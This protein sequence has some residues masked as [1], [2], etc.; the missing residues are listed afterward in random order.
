MPGGRPTKLTQ[1]QRAYVWNALFEYIQNED[2][3]TIVGFV[4]YDPAAN[5]YDVTRDNINDWPEFST[6]IKKATTKQE[7]YL[8]KNASKNRINPTFAIFRLKQPVHGYSDKTQTDLT[9]NGKDLPTPILGGVSVRSDDSN[10]Q[11]S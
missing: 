6:L 2:D 9:T 5:E 7:A 1:A 10:D 8:L 4:A 11:A 3:P